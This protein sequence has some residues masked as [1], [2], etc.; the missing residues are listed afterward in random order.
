MP[1][2]VEDSPGYRQIRFYQRT[3][4]LPLVVLAFLV[5]MELGAA[6]RVFPAYRDRPPEPA[7]FA[8]S[9]PMILLWIYFSIITN[10]KWLGGYELV[11][12][13]PYAFKVESRV[14]GITTS[15]RHFTN[16][17]VQNLRYEEWLPARAWGL[18]QMGIRFE[19]EGSTQTIAQNVDTGDCWD[20]ID[21]MAEVFR[22]PTTPPQ[23]PAEFGSLFQRQTQQGQGNMRSRPMITTASLLS[24]ALVAVALATKASQGSS[25][26]A[27]KVILALGVL[28]GGFIVGFILRGR[29]RS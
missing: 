15:S 14:L 4:P 12:V 27:G 13:T 23:E 29:R 11:T 9:I 28:V 22:F 18:W 1:I 8:F 7:M 20:L 19:Y 24:F 17:A 3:L 21:R 6:L 25:V 10:R 16:A 26:S 5:A 2:K